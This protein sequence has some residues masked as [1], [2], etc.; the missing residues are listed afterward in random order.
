MIKPSFKIS[1]LNE[2]NLKNAD[3]LE[4]VQFTWMKI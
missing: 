1:N 4:K 3:V 2:G